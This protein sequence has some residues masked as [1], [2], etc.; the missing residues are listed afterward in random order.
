MESRKLRITSSRASAIPKSARGDPSKFITNQIYTRFKGCLATRHGQKFEPV[1]RDWYAETSG[2]IIEKC[3]LVISDSEPYNAASPDGIINNDTVIEIKC[4]TKPLNELIDSGKYDVVSKED[5]LV[6][7]SK[8]RNGYYYQVQLAMFCTKTTKCKFIVWT[9]ML[10]V[11][12]TCHM[13]K[14]F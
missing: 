7:S 5:G 12:L 9:Q 13:M 3:G 10:N 4:P 1:A 14:D 11:L 6:L 2:C 8:G